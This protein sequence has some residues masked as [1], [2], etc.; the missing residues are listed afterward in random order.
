MRVRAARPD[1]YE[2]WL[3][4]WRELGITGTPPDHE[5]WSTGVMPNTIFLEEGGEL[6]AY[7]LSFAFGARGDVR[8][9]AVAPAYRRRGVGKQLMAAVAAKLRAA[10][11]T[12]WRLEVRADNAPAITLYRAAG[13]LPLRDLYIVR[14]SRE[15]CERF[16][17]RGLIV[18]PVIPAD[19][20]RL[21][22]AFGLGAGQVQRWRTF[23]P[24]C[25][26]VRIGFAALAQI[27]R[28]FAADHG[29]LFPFEAPDENHAAALIA[30]ALPGMPS[31][32]ELQ[33]AR[34]AYATL[35]AAGAR[36]VEHLV[37]FAGQL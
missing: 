17:A 18:T 24:Q 7:N 29:L 15:A 27:N 16:A 1:D 8:Q 21:E 14:I 23:R 2:A 28:E 30:E 32:Y 9:I 31:A 33:V 25:P 19:D 3:G 22:A 35:I 13:M 11:C 12:D 20:A 5:R 34:P 6:A 37:E 10:G 36:D 4:F 26:I